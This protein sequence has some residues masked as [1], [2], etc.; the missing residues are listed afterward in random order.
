MKQRPWVYTRP[1]S[2]FTLVELLIA[3]GLGSVVLG[4][5]VAFFMNLTRSS[6]AQNAAA[7][8]Q[9]S[10]RAGVEHIVNDLRM[11]GLDP[12]KTAGAGIKDHFHQHIVPR[13]QGDA[14]FMAVIGKTRVLSYDQGKVLTII[15]SAFDQ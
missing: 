3:L 1:D 11:A 14:N 12:L 7:L 5:M 9:H 8:A 15:R 6:I 10:A 4:I 2:G 13:W